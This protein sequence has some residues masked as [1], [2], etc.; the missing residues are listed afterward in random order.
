[1]V[2][3]IFI[4]VSCN[5]NN[6]VKTIYLQTDGYVI[7]APNKANISIQ[8][9]CVD[10]NIEH[11]KNCLIEKSKNLNEDLLNFGI[12]NKD[13]LTTRVDLSKEYDWLNNSSIFIGYRTSTTTNVTV[14]DLKILDTLYPILLSN[15]NYLIQNL[16]YQHSK[17]D[18]LNELAYINALDNANKLADK[19]LSRLPEK[20]KMIVQISNFKI[21]KSDD[22]TEVEYKLSRNLPEMNQETLPINIGD[23]VVEQHLYIEYKI[24]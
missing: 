7:T 14:N 19:I 6:N 21:P 23:M 16:T 11:S 13:I 10:K 5:S 15:E 18:S 1:M 9:Y 22:N 20:N 17:I 4:N 3:I 2:L 24:Y 12:Q 8:I